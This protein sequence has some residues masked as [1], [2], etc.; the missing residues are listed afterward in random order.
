M[1]STT[2]VKESFSIH[3]NTCRF[4]HF[5]CPIFK[6]KVYNACISGVC[7]HR[8]QS[9]L[10]YLFFQNHLWP[11]ITVPFL[12]LNELQYT[13]VK[14]PIVDIST[15]AVTINCTCNLQSK[16]IDTYDSHFLRI[17][18]FLQVVDITV[19]AKK[20]EKCLCYGRQSEEKKTRMFKNGRKKEN[21]NLI[22]PCFAIVPALIKT[23]HICCHEKQA[24]NLASEHFLH[25][26]HA[27]CRQGHC[28]CY[29]KVGWYLKERT[30]SMFENSAFVQMLHNWREAKKPVSFIKMSVM[31]TWKY[32]GYTNVTV[33]A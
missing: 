2:E 21:S 30:R 16:M 6:P 28:S 19:L 18:S 25:Y 31:K 1:I 13:V 26:Q 24:T 15:D 14:V 12:Q 33:I 11:N 22:D 3:F 27:V 8:S 17:F 32:H 4:G 23:Y 7:Q 20:W 10:K 5:W 9:I 29:K